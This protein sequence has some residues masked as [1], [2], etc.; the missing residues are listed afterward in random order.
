MGLR[1]N[2]I[3]GVITL[4]WFGTRGVEIHRIKLPGTLSENVY[5]CEDIMRVHSH[6]SPKSLFMSE[7]LVSQDGGHT[8]VTTL[9]VVRFGLPIMTSRHL[10]CINVGYFDIILVKFCYALP[11]K[12]TSWLLGSVHNKRFRNLNMSLMLAVNIVS[13]VA[14][15]GILWCRI[16]S[17]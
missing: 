11:D 17:V 1:T 16:R 12:W 6:L 2:D 15:I 7:H 8:F 14:K 3:Y 4:T 10:T 9:I 13:S 5:E